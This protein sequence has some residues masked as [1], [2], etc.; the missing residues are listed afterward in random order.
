[1]NRDSVEAACCAAGYKIDAEIQECCRI[2]VQPFEE[3]HGMKACMIAPTKII[4][5]LGMSLGIEVLHCPGATGGHFFLM[6][7]Y[8][9]ISDNVTNRNSPPPPLQCRPDTP[10]AGEQ[11][12]S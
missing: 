3:K 1:M 8:F 4:A 6:Q 2:R 11:C 12:T 5:G 10:S 9:L 7:R